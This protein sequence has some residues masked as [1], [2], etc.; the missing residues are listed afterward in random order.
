MIPSIRGTHDILPGEVE[1]WQHVER[2]ARELCDRYGYVE[3]RTPIIEREELFTK[4]TGATTDIVQSPEV[5]PVPELNASVV[6]VPFTFRSW[7]EHKPKRKVRFAR[8]PVH[9][10]ATSGA[11][12]A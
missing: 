9:T 12:A 8:S 3:V 6:S 1:N 10:P 5:A 7:H 11:F 4:G 2:V